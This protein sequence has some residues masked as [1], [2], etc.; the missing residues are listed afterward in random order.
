MWPEDARII[1]TTERITN[2]IIKIAIK[3]S[4]IVNQY[5]LWDGLLFIENKNSI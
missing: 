3:S 2:E 5:V 1:V 4:I